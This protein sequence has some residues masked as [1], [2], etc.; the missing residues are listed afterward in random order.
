M[1]ERHEYVDLLLEVKDG[2][3]VG[4]EHFGEGTQNEPIAEPVI[5][6]PATGVQAL[7][8]S[9]LERR[10]KRALRGARKDQEPAT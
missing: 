7:G 6:V 8:I 1:P 9:R 4:C 2:E 5:Y 10:I 3:V